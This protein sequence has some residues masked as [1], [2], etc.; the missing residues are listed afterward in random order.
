MLY[1]TTNMQHGLTLDFENV[2][3]HLDTMV[4][5]HTID[6]SDVEFV[7]PWGIVMVC[8]LLI[9][10]HGYPDRELILPAYSNTCGYLKRMHFDKILREIRYISQAEQL[11]QL[12]IPEKENLNIQEIVHCLYRDEFN[13]RLERF[14]QMFRNFGL[15]D[16]DSFLATGVVG[17]LGNNV[18][19]HNSFSWPTNISGSVIMAQNYPKMRCIEVAIG[20][21]GIG[22]RGSLAVAFPQLK[23]DVEAIRTGLAGH[24]GRIGETR[25]NGLRLIQQWTIQNFSGTVMVQ[26]GDGLVIVR[27]GQ[28]ED[29]TVQRIVGTL[30]QFVIHYS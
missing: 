28:I 1:N 21:P 9:E 3:H 17:E 30:A 27:K 2:Y 6:L 5:G 13:V 24:S 10:R 23:S 16:Q 29:R 18:F 20:D 14:I 12:V 19:D 8:L 7:H 25:G 4:R 11:E 22:F 26:S 15:S